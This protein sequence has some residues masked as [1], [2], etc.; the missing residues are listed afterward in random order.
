MKYILCILKSLI[1]G[2][3]LLLAT[4]FLPVLYTSS[5]DAKQEYVQIQESYQQIATQLGL[6]ETLFDE[7]LKEEDINQLDSLELQAQAKE[8]MQGMAQQGTYALSEEQIQQIAIELQGIYD[9]T[10][11]KV[12]ISNAL[13]QMR[14]YSLVGILG[15]ETLYLILTRKKK[16]QLEIT[17]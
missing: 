16:P 11:A 7:L 2:C 6:S 13:K 10:T 3:I 5:H 17:Q 12:D 15:C 8:I 1:I 4:T 9:R 14:T